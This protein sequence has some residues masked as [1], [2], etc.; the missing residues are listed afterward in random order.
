LARA[1][2]LSTD[3]LART[4]FLTWQSLVRA[5]LW[6]AH[7]T[8]LQES[9]ARREQQRNSCPYRPRRAK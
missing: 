9:G 6:F 1:R 3:R 8:A 7:L 5:M 2:F 4:G